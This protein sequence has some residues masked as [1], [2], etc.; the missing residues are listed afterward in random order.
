MKNTVTTPAKND[1]FMGTMSKAAGLRKFNTTTQENP[2]QVLPIE[3]G[4]NKFNDAPIRSGTVDVHYNT[5]GQK[6]IPGSAQMGKAG[7]TYP[8]R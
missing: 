5:N 8:S 6:S 2:D 4:T 7:D 1:T 3:V